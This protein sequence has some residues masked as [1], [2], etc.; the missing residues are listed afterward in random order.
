M[1]KIVRHLAV[2]KM[3]KKILEQIL[4]AQTIHL[5]MS[6][7]ANFPNIGDKL[8]YLMADIT[9][10]TNLNKAFNAT[11]P[12]A[13]KVDRDL[14]SHK[15][16]LALQ[17]LR[18]WVQGVADANMERAESI[19]LSAGMEV[20]KEASRNVADN[21]V[22]DGQE[23]GTVVLTGKG[24]GAH[25]WQQSPDQGTTIIQ[26]DP[27]MVAN[28]TVKGLVPGQKVWFRNRQVLRKGEYGDWCTWIPFIPKV[29]L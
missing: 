1:H 27:T 4:Y 26:L 24:A 20:K 10:L 7:N 19:I 5:S 29:E 11:P 16:K 12:S 21:D 18:N 22:E 25:Q 28:I 6:N 17:D 8:G 13:T 2:L 9:S 23:F 15:V 3:P 14:A